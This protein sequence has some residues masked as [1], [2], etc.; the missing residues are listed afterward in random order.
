VALVIFAIGALIVIDSLR[1]GA[2]WGADGPQTGYFPFYVALMVCLASAWNVLAALL[3]KREANAMFVAR[4]Q[5]KLVLA[6]LVPTVVFVGLVGWIG[7]YVAG[8]LFIGFFMRWLGKYAWWKVGAVGVGVMVV[9]FFIFERWFLVP[10]PKGPL[11]RL[12]GLG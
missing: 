11:E 7:L 1:I 5:L 4:G 6:V 3:A 9:L 12:L 8:A 2:R 10:L